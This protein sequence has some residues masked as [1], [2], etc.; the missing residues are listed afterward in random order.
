MKP[1][2][3]AYWKNVWLNAI[4]CA[5]ADTEA[6]ACLT[7]RPRMNESVLAERTIFN[8]AAVR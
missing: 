5:T 4:V 6:T 8:G 2:G 1:R 3:T 7:L